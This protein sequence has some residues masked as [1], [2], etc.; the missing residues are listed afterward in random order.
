MGHLMKKESLKKLNLK[1][2]IEYEKIRKKRITYSTISCKKM[3]GK[4]Y[5]ERGVMKDKILL[6]KSI[7]ESEERHVH[8]RTEEA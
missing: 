7:Q 1:L 4:Y 3:E 6:R 2:Y 8:R 5:R